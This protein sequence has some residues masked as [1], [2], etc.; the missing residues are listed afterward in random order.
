MNEITVQEM[1]NR[2]LGQMETKRRDSGDEFVSLKKGHAGWMRDITRE[3]HS[4]MAPDD[5]KYRFIELALQAI[6][7]H[8]SMDEALDSL[9]ADPYN[10]DLLAWLSSNLTRSSYVDDAVKN[11][12]MTSDSFDTMAVIGMGQVEEKREVFSLVLR[13]LEK[14][15]QEEAA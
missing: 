13:G 12:G 3:A 15:A 5:Y 9:E 2:M 10:A 6:S 7:S 4:K 14:Q 1:A 11:F 8:D